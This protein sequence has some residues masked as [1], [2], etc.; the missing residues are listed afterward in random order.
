MSGHRLAFE[1]SS[2]EGDQ[3][4]WPHLA[5]RPPHALADGV[6]AAVSPASA[7]LDG[8]DVRRHAPVHEGRRLCNAEHGQESD[9]GITHRIG[10]RSSKWDAH[11][12]TVELAILEPSGSSLWCS[13]VFAGQTTGGLRGAPLG[14]DSVS[15]W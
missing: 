13:P 8:Q 1:M 6:L 14:H 7:A 2:S 3:Y 5:V 11:V 9:E 4:G 12:R 10:Y 15:G